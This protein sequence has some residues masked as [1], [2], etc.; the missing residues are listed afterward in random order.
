MATEIESLGGEYGAFPRQDLVTRHDGRH[1]GSSPRGEDGNVAMKG[2]DH[3]PISVNGCVFWLSVPLV[4]PHVVTLPRSIAS[5]GSLH[6][7]RRLNGSRYLKTNTSKE[8]EVFDD[9]M[10]CKKPLEKG[11]RRQT[12][13]SARDALKR[14][15]NTA[16]VLSNTPPDV[17]SGESVRPN[18][19][20]SA[21]QPQFPAKRTR[22]V[23]IIDDSSTI[24]KCLAKG[25][26]RMGFA[27][28]QAEDGLRGL[29]QLKANCYDAVLLDF[30][31]PVMDGL[32]AAR[33][34]R[35]WEGKFRPDFH[36]VSACSC[37][38]LSDV[39]FKQAVS[40]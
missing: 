7:Q 8:N 4:L 28:T 39:E 5:T 11:A 38:F 24:R 22:S 13:G 25:F 23:L 3:E 20:S 18:P 40:T 12:L 33:Q 26:S 21:S 6:R 2:S 1:E 10:D 14:S 29:E 35:E 19:R 31:M 32:D 34:F 16:L 27:V 15:F 37:N 30:L 9:L 36:Q 17:A